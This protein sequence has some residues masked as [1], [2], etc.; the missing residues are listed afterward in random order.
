[1]LSIRTLRDL[2]TQLT[3]ADTTELNVFEKYFNTVDGQLMTN[4][5]R[6]NGIN[7]STTEPLPDVPV[8]TKSDVENA[9]KAARRAFKTWSRVPVEERKH[10]LEKFASAM[11]QHADDFA[12]LLTMEQGK[13][14]LCT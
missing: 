1:M 11:T 2:K 4:G 13:P 14:V 5:E 8:S 10:A 3:M 12:K 9:V 7:P 6:R